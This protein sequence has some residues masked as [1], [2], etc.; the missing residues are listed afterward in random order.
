MEL[1][2]STMIRGTTCS[3]RCC[4]SSGISSKECKSLELACST[5]IRGATGNATP[6]SVIAV[7]QVE[8][9]F[10]TMMP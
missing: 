7:S 1:A 5:M 6:G 3:S 8:S 2:C 9:A 4:S 10:T